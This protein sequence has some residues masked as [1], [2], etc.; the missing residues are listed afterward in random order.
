MG[1]TDWLVLADTA[2]PLSLERLS[3]A[4]EASAFRATDV[5]SALVRLQ[6]EG[7]N[8]RALLAKACSVDLGLQAFP[9]GRSARTRFAAMPVIIRCLQPSTFELTLALS[10][11][12]YLVAWLE[13]AAEEFSGQDPGS[14]AAFPL[15]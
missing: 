8:A 7:A 12:D 3:E 1:P 6:V 10:Y 11:R 4:F 13:D 9:I 5:S 15:A 2:A 14:S